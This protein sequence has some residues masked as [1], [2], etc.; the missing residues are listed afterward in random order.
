MPH[1]FSLPRPV[2]A[3]RA[4]LLPLTGLVL[5]FGLSAAVAQDPVDQSSIN[6]GSAISKLERQGYRDVRDAD[7]DAFD[8][9][10]ELRAINPEGEAVIVTVDTTTGSRLYEKPAG[11]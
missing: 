4:R 7:R 9:E 8:N 6:I 3:P 11:E 5:A 2:T 1:R 10:I